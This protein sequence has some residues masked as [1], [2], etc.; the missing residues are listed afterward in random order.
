VGVK[1]DVMAGKGEWIDVDDAKQVAT[2]LA[3]RVLEQGKNEL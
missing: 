1:S 3:V 2:K